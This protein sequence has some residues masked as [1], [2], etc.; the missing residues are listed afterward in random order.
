[1]AD[2][3]ICFNENE[4]CQD[5]NENPVTIQ[6]WGPIT[7]NE[8]KKL[9]NSCFKKRERELICVFSTMEN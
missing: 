1:M 7:N 6:H 3:I 4:K 9:C 2:T 8:F 5:C